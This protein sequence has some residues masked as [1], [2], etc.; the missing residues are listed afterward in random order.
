MGY[1]PVEEARGFW[2]SQSARIA[3]AAS[4]YPPPG[5]SASPWSRG[6]RNHSLESYQGMRMS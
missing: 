1:H 5:S 4:T 3:S 6:I 2:S